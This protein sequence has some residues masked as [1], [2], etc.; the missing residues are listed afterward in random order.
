MAAPPGL[1]ATVAGTALA[2]GTA[3]TGSAL[4]I[5][6]FMTMTKVNLG[7]AGAAII[8]AVAT[9]LLIEYHAKPTSARARRPFARNGILPCSE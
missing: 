2:S 5:L 4:T 3:G 7:I 9:P 8:A 6:K 1:A